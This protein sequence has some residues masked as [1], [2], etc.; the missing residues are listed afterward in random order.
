MK[1]MTELEH[2]E[3]IVMKE[4]MNKPLGDKPP[5]VYVRATENP[6]SHELDLLWSGSRGFN[7]RDERSPILF[8]IVG[9]VVGALLTGAAAFF[10]FIK[11]D[12]KMGQ[13]ALTAP[14]AEE[15]HLTPQPIKTRPTNASIVTPSGT[16]STEAPPAPVQP[17]P[18]PATPLANGTSSGIPAQHHK[19]ANGET[20]ESIAKHYYG[21]GTPD[22]IDRITKANNLK[23]PNALQLDQ[24]LLI[25]PKSY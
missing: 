4:T 7:F 20:L 14:V 12:V 17:N 2:E 5:G 9:F 24:D 23:N 10:L 15:D 22:M 16:S 3:D 6:P 18:V 19:V 8:F 13:N 25:P 21:A 1:L 11:P